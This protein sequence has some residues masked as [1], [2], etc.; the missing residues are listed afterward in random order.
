VRLVVGVEAAGVL[1]GQCHAFVQVEHAT[2]RVLLLVRCAEL[3]LSVRLLVHRC[4]G[5]PRKNLENALQIDAMPCTGKYWLGARV[6]FI[7]SQI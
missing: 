1:E 6:D 3:Q 7:W 5:V 2:R 4:C